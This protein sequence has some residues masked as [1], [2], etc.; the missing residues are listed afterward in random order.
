MTAHPSQAVV[1]PQA[2]AAWDALSEALAVHGPAP[3]EESG[4]PEA[5]WAE[6]QMLDMA[7]ACCRGCP[8]R[9]ECL[10]YAIAADE[11]FGVWGG[12]TPVER[13]G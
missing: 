2:V 8:V 7:R 12:T 4:M 6:G 11:R 9:A 10:A 5:W 13:A 1:P 3:C